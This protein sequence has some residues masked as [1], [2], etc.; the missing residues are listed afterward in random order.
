MDKTTV[1]SMLTQLMWNWVSHELSI[2]L[3]LTPN[4]VLWDITRGLERILTEGIVSNLD[5]IA[6]Q[7]FLQYWSNAFQM[8]LLGWDLKPPL[9]RWGTLTYL[10]FLNKMFIIS[11]DLAV[12]LTLISLNSRESSCIL[13]DFHQ[14]LPHLCL[15]LT[16]RNSNALSIVEIC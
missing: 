3:W 14:K 2:L 12:Y 10:Y 15:R 8:Q 9:H 5:V 4:Y 11:L 16:E 7:Q 6:D 1:L 13:L